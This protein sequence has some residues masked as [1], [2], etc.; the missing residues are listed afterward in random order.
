MSTL[1]HIIDGDSH[2]F[3]T[4][5]VR[6]D[7]AILIVLLLIATVI[8]V[9]ERRIPNWLVVSGIVIAALFHTSSPSGKGLLFA[10]SGLCTGLAILFPIYVLR[11]M[12]AGDVK[13]M[14]TI[15]AFLGASGVIGASLATMAAGGLLAIAIAGCKRTLPQLF[16]NLYIMLVQRHIRQMGGAATQAMPLPASVGKMPYALAIL[17]GTLVQLFVLRY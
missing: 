5:A 3:D 7:L 12:G 16:E 13:L 14:G 2:F 1:L 10:I 15:G 6:L 11:A 4:Y 17:T 8:D 9:R